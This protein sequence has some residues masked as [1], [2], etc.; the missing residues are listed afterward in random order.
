MLLVTSAV[1]T[2][3]SISQNG[4]SPVTLNK[5]IDNHLNKHIINASTGLF[6]SNENKVFHKHSSL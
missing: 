1:K 4:L 2:L 5:Q 6:I 3:V